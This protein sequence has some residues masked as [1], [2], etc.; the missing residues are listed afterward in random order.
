MARY[1]SIEGRTAT[2]VRWRCVK[3][4]RGEHWRKWRCQRPY[5]DY[6]HRPAEVEAK[7]TGQEED[8]GGVWGV[9]S[10]TSAE[11]Q[12]RRKQ[13]VGKGGA[14][15]PDPTHTCRDAKISVNCGGGRAAMHMMWLRMMTTMK[16]KYASDSLGNACARGTGSFATG[17]NV[18][19]T[20]YN[21]GPRHGPGRLSPSTRAASITCAIEDGEGLAMT[22]G[23]QRNMATDKVGATRKG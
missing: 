10:R 23:G 22:D 19:G 21:V 13:S 16:A 6:P 3:G 1:L 11:K 9:V 2:E 8:R 18:R 5:L 17:Y 7:Q 12:Q 14:T 4:Q 15:A 20:R